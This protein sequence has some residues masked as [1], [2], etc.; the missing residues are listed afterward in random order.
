M[1][2]T[3]ILR[4]RLVA[5]PETSFTPSGV[6]KTQFTLAIRRKFKNSQSGEYESDFIRCIAWRKT[7]E[8]TANYL[9]KGLR[10]GVIGSWQTGSF[11]GQDGKRQYTNDCNVEELDLIDFADNGQATQTP[12]E[13]YTQQYQQTQQ[14][15]Q[16]TQQQQ[17][18]QN[19]SNQSYTRVEQDPFANSKGPV[20]VS[21][22]DLP[23]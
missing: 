7:A 22:D 3:V 13:Q 8:L 21:E 15:G 17:P 14:Q 10:V 6:Q 12:G 23:F 16:Q 2:N 19:Q 4:G 18:A 5:D 1:T 20:E 11:E 9:R